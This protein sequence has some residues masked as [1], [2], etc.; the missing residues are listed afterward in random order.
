MKVAKFFAVIFAAAGIVLMLGSCVLCFA[1]LNSS[2]KIMEYPQQA[3]DCSQQLAD[4]L[5]TGDFPALEKLLYGQP[6]LGTE[7]PS[8]SDRTRLLWNAFRKNTELTYS[9]N[10]YL[11]DSVLAR[12]GILTV[13][14]IPALLDQVDTAARN[15][16]ILPD[17]AEPTAQQVE[18]ALDAALTQVLQGELPKT[19]HNTTVRFIH[20]DGRWWAV[21]DQTFL[22]TVSGQQS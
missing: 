14:D 17:G 21:P 8:A 13:P 5:S 16:L 20:R 11:L 19:T 2:V 15:L 10:L 18:Q 4:A 6:S 22:Q 1:S 9:G 12:D 7:D 3:A